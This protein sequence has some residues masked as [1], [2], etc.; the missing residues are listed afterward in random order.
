MGCGTLPHVSRSPWQRYRTLLELAPGPD[1]AAR[2]TYLRHALRGPPQAWPEGLRAFLV[3]EGVG[4][5][6][7][8][9]HL[10]SIRGFAPDVRAALEAGLPLSVARLVN[11]VDAAATRARVLAPLAEAGPK[12]GALLPR[13]LAARIERAARAELVAAA[14][15][16]LDDAVPD[17]GWIAADGAASPRGQ[18][19]SVWTFPP[20]P[21]AQ[22][23]AEPLHE[24]VIEG[25]LARI[26][27]SGGRLVDVTAGRGTIARVARRHGVATWSG[28]LEPG[29][30]FVHRVDAARLFDVP[31][32]GL[33]RGA[34]DALVVHPPTYLA[35]AEATGAT[36]LELDAYGDAVGTMITGS[37]GVVRPGGFVVVITRPVREDGRVWL[38]TSHLAQTL[39]DAGL[40]LTGYVVAVSADGAEDWHVLV[41]Q[42]VSKRSR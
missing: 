12:R 35:W 26:L 19:G 36:R 37:L 20:T 24:S 13:G 28:D 30:P 42:D 1:E 41:A 8:L 21:A 2:V 7:V 23:P 3:E 34:A 15:R 27:P 17:D 31:P 6:Y 39:D 9:R 32:P 4:A 33:R 38:T 14:P 16:A 10:L 5:A 29:A 18:P 11:G 25:V 40:D 22:R